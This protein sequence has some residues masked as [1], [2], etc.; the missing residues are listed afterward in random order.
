MFGTDKHILSIQRKSYD[1][2]G[3]VCYVFDGQMQYVGK[4][5]GVGLWKS[6]L[7]LGPVK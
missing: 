3:P 4:R 5:E 7:F 6:R 2:Y 1:L